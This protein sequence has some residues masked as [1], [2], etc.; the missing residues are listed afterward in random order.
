M[1]N[2]SILIS[3]LATL[4]LLF[5]SCGDEGFSYDYGWGAVVIELSGMKLVVKNNYQFLD[6]DQPIVWGR[7]LEYEATYTNIAYYW[8][9]LPHHHY[10]FERIPSKETS[11]YLNGFVDITCDAPTIEKD[12]TVHCSYIALVSQSQSYSFEGDMNIF[13]TNAKLERLFYI[14]AQISNNKI[15]LRE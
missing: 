3:A 4:S 11:A 10:Y 2:R 5:T 15:S 13:V 14:T 6:K 1:K 8:Q 12:A 9:E 7:Y